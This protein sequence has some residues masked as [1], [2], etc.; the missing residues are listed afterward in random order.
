MAEIYVYEPKCEDFTNF[1]LVGTLTPASCV[2]EEEANGMSEITLEHPMD[3]LGRYRA[4]EINNLLMVP[5][6]VRTTPEIEED[7]VIDGV[8]TN[9]AA[10]VTNV[11]K[12][13]VLAA[14]PKYRTLYKKRTGSARIK[15]LTAGHELTVVRKYEE[16]RWKVK[17][18]YGTGWMVQS[19][20]SEEYEVE[21]ENTAT[22]IE[23]VEPAWTVKPQVFRIYEVRKG[24]S[25]VTVAA[26]HITYDLLYNTTTYKN[27]ASVSCKDALKA[28]FAEENLS[29]SA[30]DF[31]AYTNLDNEYAGIDWTRINPINALLDPDTGLTALFKAKLV[32][33]NW[34]MYF[35]ANPGMD[36]GVTV[37][38]ARNMTG[39]EYIENT[40][41]IVTRIIPIGET[42]DGK[43]LLYEPVLPPGVSG[44]TANEHWVNSPRTVY[45][46]GVETPIVY[47]YPV[48]FT[49][50]LEC[51]N[52]KVGS[53]GI[54]TV[55]QARERM[56][57]QALAL[58]AQ[59]I[60]LPK[61]EMSV[62]F[63][64]LGDTEEYRQFK[65]LERLFLFDKVHVR[66]EKQGIDV[67]A[68]IVSIKWDCLLERMERMEIG[69]AIKTL[70]NTQTFSPSG[71]YIVKG[72]STSGGALEG[73][74]YL[75]GDP[76]EPLEAATKHYVDSEI[77]KVEVSGGAPGVGIDNITI[78]EVV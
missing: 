75:K 68:E 59:D 52:C 63:I 9:T 38:Y 62:D 42:K 26:R 18:E 74:L 44:N 56:K 4:L 43:P 2:F 6:P 45:V 72:L 40:D 35:L 67:L 48:I 34:E 39:I 27:D 22:A 64:D 17:S 71:Q 7:V 46:D 37:E 49:M 25:S 3:D 76:T 11:W 50:V 58:F 47:A 1:G 57:E 65:N 51:E 10:F 23:S 24:I 73:G 19:V 41:E 8:Q 30:G 69:S 32:R 12:C 14:V 21:L 55:A 70:A 29:G 5:V 31:E 54:T 60:D 20:L 78:E 61:I 13:K 36:R 66:H 53:G 33:D 15:V 16:G 77:A 28:V